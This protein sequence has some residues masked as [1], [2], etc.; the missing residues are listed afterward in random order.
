MMEIARNNKLITGRDGNTQA[1]LIK[2][3]NYTKY[4]RESVAHLVPVE[5][6]PE[7]H[8]TSWFYI[9]NIVYDFN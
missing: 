8:E 5:L 4:L 7:K 3:P 6:Q 2:V 1:A 9:L